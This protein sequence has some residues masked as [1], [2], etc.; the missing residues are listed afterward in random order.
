[1]ADVAASAAVDGP[2]AAPDRAHGTISPERAML[3]ELHHLLAGA[4]HQQTVL[5]ESL[6]TVIGFLERPVDG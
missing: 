4:R 6:A 3:D 1:V 2:E 5:R